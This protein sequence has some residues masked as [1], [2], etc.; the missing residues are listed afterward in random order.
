MRA[1][2][3]LEGSRSVRAGEGVPPRLIHAARQGSIQQRVE[4][5]VIGG[6]L[7]VFHHDNKMP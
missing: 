3:L 1:G 6:L 2:R 4:R 5:N 7:R